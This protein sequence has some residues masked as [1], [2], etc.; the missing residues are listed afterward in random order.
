MSEAPSSFEKQT[1]E[2]RLSTKGLENV[3][4]LGIE[5]FTL[6]VGEHSISCS[7]FEAS[8]LSP[9]ITTAIF[10]DAT[11]S[12]YELDVDV[13]KPEGFDLNCLTEVVSLSR[14]RSF[15]LTSSNFECLKAVGKSLGNV[16]LCDQLMEFTRGTSELTISNVS[17]RL[18]VAE[19][20]E[21]SPSMEIEYLASHFYEIDE[22]IVKSL[23]H[24]SLKEVLESDGLQLR[25]EDSL[26]N[27]ILSPGG[28]Y[29]DLLGC[30]R[31]EYLSV[32]GI[33]RLLNLISIEEVDGL[34]WSSL[35]R[36]LRSSVEPPS[37]PASRFHLKRFDLDSSRPF[38]GIIASLTREC[39]GNVHTQKVVSITASSNY[40]NQCYQVADYSWSS[41]WFS[42]SEA[43]SWIQFDFKDRR[44]SVT[45]YSIKSDG[46][47]GSHLQQWSIEG[48]NDFLSWI[49]LDER[50]THELN[51]NYVVKSYE[52]ESDQ[53]S[54]FPFIRLTQTGTNSSN[55]NYLMRGNVEFF[56]A[57]HGWQNQ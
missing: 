7:R 20:L 49:L 6:R 43:N 24:S 8:F 3:A 55:N 14:N 4:A 36:R 53:S 16:E 22:N 30:V 32:S 5:D 18:A 26:L 35:S 25:S 54:F 10:N 38:D 13:E 42:Y 11:L 28:D 40:S 17:A 21:V 39:G 48:S 15:S 46:N 56:A 27:L 47:G 45:N 52:C 57:F 34:L 50:N 29:F 1:Q 44:I 41:Y 37:I 33:D 51:G 31:S 2:L 23:S 12:E 19:S 9:R